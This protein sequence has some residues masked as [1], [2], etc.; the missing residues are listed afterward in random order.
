MICLAK[1]NI[2]LSMHIS[3]CFAIVYNIQIFIRMLYHSFETLLLLSFFYLMANASKSFFRIGPRFQIVP[4]AY[5]VPPAY[6]DSPA[7][8]IL[9]I[10]PTFLLIRSPPFIRD[11]RVFTGADSEFDNCF[12]KFR[13]Q[14]TFFGGKLQIA[15]NE[16]RH[17]GAFKG[18]DSECGNKLFSQNTFFG[19]IWSRNS[20]ILCF[21]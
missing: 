20:K 5:P 10:V 12:L 4:P 3:I 15:F 19:E 14:N 13:P 18:A 11:P 16:T 2:L 8:L 1:L 21:F 6:S 9:P 7:Y 17:I